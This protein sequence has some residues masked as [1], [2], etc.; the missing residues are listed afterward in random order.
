M[1]NKTRR[2]LT[3]PLPLGKKLHLG[4]GHSADI[5]ANAAE[6][7]A[8]RKLIDAGEIAIEAAGPGGGDGYAGGNKGRASRGHTS[9]IGRRSGDR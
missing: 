7:P 1:T 5:P 3:I 6:H 2:P 4:P 8:V 9:F